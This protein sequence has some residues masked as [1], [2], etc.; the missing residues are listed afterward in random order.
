MS[1][2]SCWVF[3]GSDHLAALLADGWEESRVTKLVYGEFISV[4]MVLVD[5]NDKKGVE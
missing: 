4:L 3:R 1:G 5:D 2:Y